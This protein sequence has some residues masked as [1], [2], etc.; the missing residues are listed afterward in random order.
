MAHLKNIH[1]LS[2]L[3]EVDK[4][5]MEH[6]AREHFRHSNIVFKIEHADSTTHTVVFN[7]TQEKS[8]AG[9][10]HSRSRLI[11]V[12]HESFDRFFRG[13]KVLV[14]PH[15]YIESPVTN[16][17]VSWIQNKMEKNGIKMKDILADTSLNGPYL[18][19]IVAGSEPLSQIM[20]SFFY[21]YFKAKELESVSSSRGR[22]AK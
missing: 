8:S 2:W 18:R 20:K 17:D 6:A 10:Y 22:R 19:S 9:A 3:S 21:Y 7:V 16:V 11:Q 15:P 1:R 14:H 12:V 4:E 13:W 5:K